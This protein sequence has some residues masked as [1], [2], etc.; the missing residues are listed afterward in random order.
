MRSVQYFLHLREQKKKSHWELYPV[1]REG[2]PAQLFVYYIK[3]PSQAVPC[4][5]MH[6]LDGWHE[7]TDN[8][9]RNS[10][11]DC[12]RS[13]TTQLWNADIATSSDD[14]EVT[15]ATTSTLASSRTLLLDLIFIN[16]YL[17]DS[18]IIF[19]TTYIWRISH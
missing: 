10:E 8:N 13:T 9:K 12:H 16:F 6:C 7:N 1:K 11:G 18:N 15:A 4:E 5:H 17:I 2:V 19:L 14:T 3:T